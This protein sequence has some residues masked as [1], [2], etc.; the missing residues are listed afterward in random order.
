DVLPALLVARTRHVRVRELVDECN[1]RMPGQDCVDVHLFELAA[2][3]L[4]DP[5]RDDFEI[6]DLLERTNASVRLD[7]THD[8]IG[9][10]IVA[11]PTF[12]EHGEG[13]ADAGGSAEV[14]AQ[15][16]AGHVVS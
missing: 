5:P 4:K 3:V 13:L 9:A 15:V 10:T 1:T 12:V 11:S 16:A 14:D 8:D 2:A 7:E 6:A